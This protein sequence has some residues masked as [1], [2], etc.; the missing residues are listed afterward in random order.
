MPM[1]DSILAFT[2]KIADSVPCRI[3][4]S[5]NNLAVWPW[6]IQHPLQRDKRFQCVIFPDHYIAFTG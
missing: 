3:R 6:S 5:R 2:L 1:I 4:R